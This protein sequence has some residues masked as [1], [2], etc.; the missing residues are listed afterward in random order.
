MKIAY[1]DCFSGA[2]GDMIVASM[3]DAGLDPVFLKEQLK[4]LGLKNLTL[5]ISKVKRQHLSAAFFKPVFPKQSDSRNLQQITKI[6]TESKISQK[7][8]KTAIS[9]FEKLAK[10]EAAVHNKKTSEIYFHEVGA[11]DSIADIVSAAIGLD[12]LGIE[13]VYCSTLSVGGE[14]V[15]SEHGRDR[16]KCFVSAVPW[17][18]YGRR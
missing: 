1:F 7:A 3:L 2:A 16:V 8:K 5:K 13:K 11:V 12:A 9:I 17:L 14:M 10:A 15:K 4:T 6:I 18:S